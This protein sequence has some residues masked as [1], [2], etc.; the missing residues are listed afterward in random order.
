[1][2]RFPTPLARV[3]FPVAPGQRSSKWVDVIAEPAGTKGQINYFFRTRGWEKLTMPAGA[4]DAIRVDVL[5][6]LDD[7]TAFPQCDQLQLHVLVLAGRARHGAGAAHGAV[8]AA[9]PAGGIPRARRVLRARELHARQVIGAQ[10]PENG[11]PTPERCDESDDDCARLDAGG[12]L[13]LAGG[14][15][16]AAQAQ[17][18]PAPAM[19]VGDRW[20]YNVKSGFGLGVVTYQ[21][22]RE[23]TAVGGGGFKLT[24]TGKTSDNKDFTRVDEYSASGA[25][26]SGAPCADEAYRFPTP[27]QRVAFPVAP[28]QR[29]SKWVDVIA[30]PGGNK[31]RSIISFA[32]EAGRSRRCLPGPSTPSASKRTMVLDDSTPFREATTCNFTYWYSPAVRGTVREQRWAQYIQIGDMQGR[33]PVLNA[34]YELASFT[35]GK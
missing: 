21:E 15:V 3:T 9:R 35:P 17:S 26:R 33:M 2:Y 31:G 28:G 13:V 18:A 12:G 8:H 34:Y 10:P 32:P 27:L 5:M 7:S 30:E 16:N 20:V 14:A 4:F 25:L 22:T 1:M 24:V 11:R 23:V 29:S 19:K 6:V